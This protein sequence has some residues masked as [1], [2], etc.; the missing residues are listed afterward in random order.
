MPIPLIPWLMSM[1]L[2]KANLPQVTVTCPLL[3]TITY[4]HP[5]PCFWVDDFPKFPFG[6]MCCVFPGGF[7]HWVSFKW[8]QKTDLSPFLDLHLRCLESSKHILPNGVFFMVIHHGR[9][10]KQSPNKQPHDFAEF[11]TVSQ[12]NVPKGYKYIYICIYILY[13]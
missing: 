1:S 7:F 10:P 6:G 8:Y 3:Q 9:I 12:D 2:H 4:P 13:I 5:Y 11:W